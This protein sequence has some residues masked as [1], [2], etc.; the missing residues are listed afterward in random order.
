MPIYEYKCN[1][2]GYKFE[3]FQS[4]SEDPVRTC[5]RCGG[6]VKRL[7]SR[8]SFILRGTG[9]YATDYAKK[10]GGSD[11]RTSREERTP[12]KC[13]SCSSGNCSNYSSS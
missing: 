4:F 10:N 6:E 3:R 2:C 1:L 12:S 5:P 13:S 11:A 9:W 7:I 8:S